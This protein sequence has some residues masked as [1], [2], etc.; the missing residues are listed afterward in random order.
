MDCDRLDRRLKLEAVLPAGA[1]LAA[2]PMLAVIGVLLWS[3]GCGSF[4][5]RRFYEGEGEVVGL[6]TLGASVFVVGHPK[7]AT[8]ADASGA[9]VVS[10]MPAGLQAL[11]TSAN[12]MARLRELRAVAG[13]RAE[14]GRITPDQRGR[15]PE[16]LAIGTCLGDEAATFIREQS[17][18]DRPFI[19]FVSI[20]E[21][22]PP[23]NGP[24]NDLYPAE[25]IPD[26]P[27]FLK[28]LAD[29]S[30]LFKRLRA[31]H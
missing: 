31:E 17:S 21:P 7:L 10:Q 1:S 24:L 20:F 27:L 29:N 26:G 2:A 9:F 8:S 23:Y 19:L 30:P 6:T 18:S 25:T 3:V 14:L 28:E 12:G 4:E 15:L 11:V 13:Q 22:H 5:N 16:E